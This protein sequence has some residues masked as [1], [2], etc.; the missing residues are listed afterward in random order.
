MLLRSDIA[1]HQNVPK[2]YDLDV[3]HHHV[4]NTYVFTEQDLPG[5]AEKNK[6]KAE[7]IKNGIPAHLLNQ[8]S[9][10]ERDNAGQSWERRKKG[11]I[12]PRKS[13]PSS[14]PLKPPI[15]RANPVANG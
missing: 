14:P 15:C 8:K 12:P 1:E 9:K 7:A 2:E 11:G 13:I 4:N 6:A 3:A 5:Y 10:G